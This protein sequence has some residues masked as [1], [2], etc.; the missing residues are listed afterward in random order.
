MHCL[1]NEHCRYGDIRR[2]LY[3]IGE[4]STTAAILQLEVCRE[5]NKGALF[6]PELNLLLHHFKDIQVDFDLSGEEEKGFSS[7]LIYA[8]SLPSVQY[9]AFD[10]IGKVLHPPGVIAQLL[11]GDRSRQ[12]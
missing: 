12:W 11:P 4:Q 1:L 7:N 9:F 2:G 3:C 10:H 5:I 6:Q 8:L